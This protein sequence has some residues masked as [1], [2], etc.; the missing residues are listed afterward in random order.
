MDKEFN[1][2]GSKMNQIGEVSRRHSKAEDEDYL[3]TVFDTYAKQG[4]N[5]QGKPNGTDVLTKDK[6][7][8]ASEE[9]IMKWNDLPEQNAKKYLEQKFDKTWSK[10]DVNG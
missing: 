3:K 5:K 4:T 1:D 8:E 6:A 9:V 2:A 10:V 7:Y